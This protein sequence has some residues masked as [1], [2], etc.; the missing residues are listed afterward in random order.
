MIVLSALAYPD[1]N[2]S[3][4]FPPTPGIPIRYAVGGLVLM[5]MFGVWRRWKRF[6]HFA[7]LV[8]LRSVHS[9]TGTARSSGIR[10]AWLHC[11]VLSMY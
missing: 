10:C 4:I 7:H 6:D 2:V 3:L 11:D 5:D 8:E 9:T 1:I